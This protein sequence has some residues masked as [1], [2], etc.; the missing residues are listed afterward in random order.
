MLL[1]TVSKLIFWLWLAF[2]LIPAIMVIASSFMGQS[3]FSEYEA[4]HIEELEQGKILVTH[5]AE[6]SS[7]P[8]RI[9]IFPKPWAG[10]AATMGIVLLVFGLVFLLHAPT[11][12]G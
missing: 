1:D 4:Q 7:G 11:Q 8:I 10:V 9:Q 12:I 5:H 6:I 3:V 2:G